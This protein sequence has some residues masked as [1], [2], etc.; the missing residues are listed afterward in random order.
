MRAITVSLPYGGRLHLPDTP[1]PLDAAADH[2]SLSRARR[3]APGRHAGRRPARAFPVLD[4]AGCRAV[5]CLSRFL[6]A[7]LGAPGVIEGPGHHLCPRCYEDLVADVERSCTEHVTRQPRREQCPQPD[8]GNSS[9]PL[10]GRLGGCLSEPLG[11]VLR[12]AGHQG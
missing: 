1:G 10:T 11:E 3:P 2:R 9:D 6:P 8:G 4:L 7:W 12:C 5:P